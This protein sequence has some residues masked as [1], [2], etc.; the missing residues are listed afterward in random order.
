ML[1]ADAMA[2]QGSNQAE[3]KFLRAAER[4]AEAFAEA[5]TDAFLLRQVRRFQAWPPSARLAKLKT[6][7]LRRAGNKAYR[8]DGV[9]AAVRLWRRSASVSADIPDSVG[10]ARATGNI[11]AGYYA[12]GRYDSAR[13]YLEEARRLALTSGDYR[14][15]ANALT[16]LAN[17]RYDNADLPAAAELYRRAIEIREQIGDERGLAADEHNLGL[18]SYSLGDH[19]GAREQLERSLTLNRRGGYGIEAADD[20]VALADVASATGGYERAARL[21]SEAAITFE[22]AGDRAGLAA[23]WQR[24]GLLDLKRGNYRAAAE[25]FERAHELYERLGRVIDAAESMKDAA[26]AQAAT[27]ELQMALATLGDAESALARTNANRRLRADFALA[28]ADLALQFNDLDQAWQEYARAE[29]LFVGAADPLGR[30]EARQGAGNLLLLREE[31]EQAADALEEVVDTQQQ[32]EENRSAALTRLLLARAELGAGD[33]RNARSNIIRAAGDF[34]R[35]GDRASQALAMAELGDME[36]RVGSINMARTAYAEGLELL[37]EW[38]PPGVSPRLHTGLGELAKRTRDLALAERELR[39][40]VDQITRVAV[41]ISLPA[42]R[43]A[44]MADKW[45]PFAKLA[46]VQLLAGDVAGAFSTSE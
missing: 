7:S 22:R 4:L 31:Y 30:A 26:T 21:L 39:T 17:V 45:E 5:W 38:E 9:E 8:E 42:H 29:E 6:D 33:T 15:A 25:E 10:I 1:L 3:E 11:G 13:V 43:S 32:W 2:A 27:G 24:R 35:L 23:V 37:A 12:A 40:A 36:A 14:T 41:Q 34:A 28:T 19:D 20:L 18:V 46:E 16:N 44:F